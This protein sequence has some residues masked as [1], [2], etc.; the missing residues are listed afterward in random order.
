[1]SIAFIDSS[2]TT[3]L[4]IQDNSIMS[5]FLLMGHLLLMCLVLF[6]PSARKLQINTKSG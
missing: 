3:M 4:Y 5:I 6:Q 1:M 2:N